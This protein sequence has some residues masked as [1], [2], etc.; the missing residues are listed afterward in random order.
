MI[1]EAIVVATPRALERVCGLTLVARAV[2]S[3]Q[4]AGVTRAVIVA[5]DE[6]VRQ[7]AAADRDVIR[8][9]IQI[10][11]AAALAGATIR[12]DDAV[13][14]VHAERVADPALIKA[15]AGEKIAPRA[16]ELVTIRDLGAA[17]C[18]FAHAE[19]APDTAQRLANQGL[20]RTVDATSWWVDVAAAGRRAAEK[21][22][23]RSLAKRV[24]GP[25]ARF[26]NRRFSLLVTRLLVGTPVT[27]N[28]MTVVANVIGAIGVWWCFQATWTGVALG[29]VFLQLQSILDGCDG[30]IARLKFRSSRFGEW[31]DN[32]LDDLVNSSY[33]V[34]L[35]YAATQL[36]GNGLWLRLGIAAAAG[37]MIYNVIVYLQLALVH[38]SGNP[39]AFRWWFQ[40]GDG[41]LK[42]ELE[43]G[44]LGGRL[45][46]LFRALARR[47]VFLFAFMLLA[48]ARLPQAAVVWY[49]VIAAPTVTMAIVHVLAGG[50]TA[51]AHA[52]A[53][54][55]VSTPPA[56]LGE[57]VPQSGGSKVEVEAR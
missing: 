26:I 29:G 13:L 17:A 57:K 36:T 52:Q 3:L 47:D 39:F 24:D 45:M 25:V 42:A 21:T 19:L 56:T 15:L 41:D 12:P 43:Q 28:M 30:E 4:R 49:A 33:G 6:R 55:L 8:A 7:A 34:G 46:A 51:H 16:T 1:R 23:Y 14:V 32:I 31:L 9:G 22:L 53:P 10:E 35:G 20:A 54:A 38:R 11:T 5:A 27:P 50:M 44:G 48:I 37:F 40:K 2:F 18:L